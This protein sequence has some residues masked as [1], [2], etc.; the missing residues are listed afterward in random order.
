[1]KEPETSRLMH[2]PEVPK[3]RA[4]LIDC[5][6]NGSDYGPGWDDATE[7]HAFGKVFKYSGKNDGCYRIFNEEKK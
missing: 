3:T 1:M 5:D 2:S 7:I 6:G 4:K